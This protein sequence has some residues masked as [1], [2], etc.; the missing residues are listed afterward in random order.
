[1]TAEVVPIPDDTPTPAVP[2]SDPWA[3]YWRMAQRIANT[4][5]VPAGLRGRP[6]AVLAVALYGEAVGIHPMIAL[7]QIS[8]IAGKPVPSAE[9]Q[10][11][12]ILAAGHRLDVVE[13]TNAR[14]V[15]HGTRTDGSELTVTFTLED[16]QRAGLVKKG[17]AWTT[18]PAAMLHARAT[19][20][21]AR[22]L[23]PDAIGGMSYLA[24]E[25][26]NGRPPVP[27]A[28]VDRHATPDDHTPDDLADRVAADIAH[29]DDP[30]L[31]DDAL[32]PDDPERPF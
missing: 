14:A 18:Y 22:A 24:E 8:F 30:A 11:S 19:S 21:L 13:M 29:D 28:I 4:E 10:R 23:F 3:R 32:N 12:L 9:L 17:G 26:D 15:V 2:D 31:D 6:D 5:M 1:M 27:I 16:A 20:Q 7:Q 25:L